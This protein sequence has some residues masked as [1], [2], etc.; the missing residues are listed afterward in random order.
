MAWN[1]YEEDGNFCLGHVLGFYLYLVDMGHGTW[2]M[3]GWGHTHTHKHY[4]RQSKLVGVAPLVT[5]PSPINSTTVT[6]TLAIIDI[7]QTM[8]NLSFWLHRQI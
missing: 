7:S 3:E 4:T 2:D 6:D 8:V 5:D 1:L